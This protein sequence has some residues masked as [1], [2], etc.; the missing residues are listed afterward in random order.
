MKYYTDVLKKYAVFDGRATRKEYWM[1]ALINMLISIAIS[2]VAG[3]IK[4]EALKTLYGLAVFLPGL[5]V[6]ARRLH[7]TNRS[8]WWM[9]LFF[10]P[11]VGWVVLIV[12]LAQETKS[13][14]AVEAAQSTHQDTPQSPQM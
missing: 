12:F 7:D 9:L 8:A 3:I 13:P 11:I 1:F 2:I 6:T 4:F 5:A 10:V 14:A